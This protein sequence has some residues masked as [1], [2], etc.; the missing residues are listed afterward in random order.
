MGIADIEKWDRICVVSKVWGYEVWYFNTETLCMK[1]LVIYPGHACSDHYHDEKYEVFTCVESG[2]SSRL[3]ITINGREQLMHVG[4]HVIIKQGEVHNFRC[5]GDKPAALLEFSTHHRE[6]DS[7]R[8]TSSH[9]FAGGNSMDFLGKV[10]ELKGRKVLCIGDICLDIYRRGVVERL[11]PEAPCPVLLNAEETVLAGCVGNVAMNV[12]AL[13]GECSVIAVVGNDSSGLLLFNML[14]NA[15]VAMEHIVRLDSRPTITKTRYMAGIHHLLRED[16]EVTEDV[17]A[18]T[19]AAIKNALDSALKEW[20]PNIV[21][22]ADY[23]K[24]MLTPAVIEYIISA[25]NEAGIPTVVDPKL[26]NFFEYKKATVLKPNDKRAGAVMKMPCDTESE[27]VALSKR[28]L[29]TMKC[30]NVLL[31][32]GG[33]GMYLRKLGDRDTPGIHIPAR[34]VEVSELSG[35][36]DTAGAALAL[37]MAAGWD[38]EDAANVSN[39]AASLVVRKSGTAYCTPS[40]L[41]EALG[42]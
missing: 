20:K 19:Q 12:N 13:G 36:G 39:V 30:G 32:R 35:A 4:Q 15:T 21:Y 37:G 28:I 11:S 2:V 17:N 10:A 38:I 9:Q 31:T 1:L 42:N 18:E 41:A 8:L 29:E 23:D 16:A 7:K 6:D 14:S 26:R 22:I 34:F 33:R 5:E 25:C 27:I 3:Y 24:G 40:E